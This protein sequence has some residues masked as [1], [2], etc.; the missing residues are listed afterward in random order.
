[1][2]KTREDPE[3]ADNN[4]PTLFRSATSYIQIIIVAV[5]ILMSIGTYQNYRGAQ[6]DRNDIADLRR[7]Q[8]DVELFD[9]K[10]KDKQEQ[11]QA[12]E[13]DTQNR[14]EE[15]RQ[16]IGSI[17]NEFGHQS[18]L[19]LSKNLHELKSKIDNLQSEL[20]ENTTRNKND[21]A[22]LQEKLSAM[23]TD[24]ETIKSGM[25][26]SGSELAQSRASTAEQLG[27]LRKSL[28]R[29]TYEFEL[30]GKGSYK[31][32]TS[33]EIRLEGT[34][35]KSY[36]FSIDITFDGHTI[37]KSDCYLNEAIYVQTKL[38]PT[39]TEIVI[40]TIDTDLVHGHLSTS[41]VSGS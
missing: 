7:R 30:K 40:D 27:E 18:P 37:Q 29:N 12:R 15:I 2:L 28:R 25:Q 39:P 20:A 32:I 14:L 34:K 1:M 36:Q 33:I 41:A 35:P 23:Q 8:G 17:H 19:A 10:L 13:A 16:R 26:A 4:G 11:A 3:F 24:L 21:I 22:N 6:H 31:T 9:K 38:T 5:A